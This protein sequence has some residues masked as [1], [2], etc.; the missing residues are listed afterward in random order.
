MQLV[1]TYSSYIYIYMLQQKIFWVRFEVFIYFKKSPIIFPFQNE[2]KLMRT[3]IM[4]MAERLLC[5]ENEDIYLT[6]V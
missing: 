6:K 2:Q 4:R 5:G 1:H 3:Y